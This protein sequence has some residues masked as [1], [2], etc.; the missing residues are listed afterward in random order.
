MT[1][2]IRSDVGI[3]MNAM[4]RWIIHKKDDFSYAWSGS[5]WVRVSILPYGLALGIQSCNFET[6]ADAEAY[7]DRMFSK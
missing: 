5:R 1:D 6:L 4:G 2:L 3:C 7:L